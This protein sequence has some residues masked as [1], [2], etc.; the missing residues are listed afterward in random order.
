MQSAY[1]KGKIK[2]K[3][4]IN[5][6]TLLKWLLGSSSSPSL[7][8]LAPVSLSEH[9]EVFSSSTE[10]FLD[11]DNKLKIKPSAKI[12]NKEKNTTHSPKAPFA[13]YCY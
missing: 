6:L 7:E 1:L 8:L 13:D 3:F 11:G 12:K 10:H 2:N 9:I 4:S 5:K